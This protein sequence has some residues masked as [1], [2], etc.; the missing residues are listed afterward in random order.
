M[1]KQYV[2]IKGKRVAVSDITSKEKPFPF[3]KNFH[4]LSIGEMGCD[5]DGYERNINAFE[6]IIELNQH[7]TGF[8]KKAREYAEKNIKE[9]QQKIKDKEAEIIH[10]KTMTSKH[11]LRYGKN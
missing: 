5:I 10:R 8:A 6:K 7:Q 9:L 1:P 2:T 11:K 4:E 3:S